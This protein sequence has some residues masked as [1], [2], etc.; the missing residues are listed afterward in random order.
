MYTINSEELAYW[1]LRLNGC[2][3]IKNFV[4]HPDNSGSARTDVDILAVRFPFRMELYPNTMI[5]D[6]VFTN[7]EKKLYI[8]ITEVKL[9]Q[10][11]WNGPWTDPDR[12]NMQRVLR[13]IGA[14]NQKE[15]DDATISL[16]RNG[17]FENSEY[18]ISLFCIGGE[19]NNELATNF[20]KVPQKLW[21][22]ILT[23]IFNRF[24][25]YNGQKAHH[26]QWEGGG[27]TLWNCYKKNRN[28]LENF[29]DNIQIR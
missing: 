28:S 19:K 25:K 4:V 16:Y 8:I 18:F 22:E 9:K 11:H 2:L 13:A 15:I 24:S 21:S 20:P 23:F 7:N 26:K 6:D 1:Y 10:C 17:Y 29:I 27:G 3:T 12:Q 14:L 5:D